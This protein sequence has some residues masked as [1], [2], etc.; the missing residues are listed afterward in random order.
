MPFRLAESAK[1]EHQAAM[2]ALGRPGVG[3]GSASP[4]WLRRRRTRGRAFRVGVLRPG[5]VCARARIDRSATYTSVADVQD[6]R[7][8]S[9]S[10]PQIFAMTA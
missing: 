1:V 3:E 9:Y 4:V 6:L 10:D 8:A 5:D 7:D 2:V